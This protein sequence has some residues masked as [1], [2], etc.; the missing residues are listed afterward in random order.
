MSQWRTRTPGGALAIGPSW[1]RTEDGWYLPEHTLAWSVMD[2][3]SE[4]LVQPDGDGA[5]EQW[6]WTQEQARLLAWWYAIDESGR[7]IYRRGVLRRLKGWGKDPFA[8][9]VSLVEF[10]GPC[11]FGGWEPDGSP[12]AVPATP[13]WVQVVGAAREQTKNTMTLI[14]PMLGGRDGAR[15]LGVDLGKEVL[16]GP[17]SARLES[18]TSSPRT[19]EGGRPS[20]VVA[21]ETHQWVSSNEGHELSRVI[22]RNLAK[23]RDG[24]ARVL[25]ITNSHEPGDGS[26]GEA[27]WDAW[28]AIETG[29]ATARDFLYDSLEAGPDTKLTD[30]ASL[31]RGLLGARGDS[32]W[33]D[34]DRLAAEI[35]DPTTPVSIS[36]RFYLNQLVASDDSLFSRQEWDACEAPGRIEEGEAVTMFFDGSH[37]DDHTGLVICRVEDGLLQVAGYWRPEDFGGQIPRV[38]VDTTVEQM[39]HRY[40][41]VGFFADRRYWESYIDSWAI[42]YGKS[43][44]IWAGARS[45][46]K[47]HPI[48]FDM[49]YRT[50]EFC[51]ACARFVVDV[52]DRSLRHDGNAALSQHV[53]NT[54]RAVTRYGFSVRKISPDSPRKIDLT[55]CAIGAREIRRRLLAAGVDVSSGVKHEVFAF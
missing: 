34:V 44:K 33:L 38:D 12:A 22:Q 42:K 14:S 49:R 35:M 36:R 17:R 27:D 23:N 20:L 50:E 29:K 18:V 1:R 25:A 26:V 46:P 8:A 10:L 21:N 39:F 28:E 32:V 51:N 45:G 37:S 19:L 53:N 7:F 47:A 6:E 52:T 24:S 13:A 31:R 16:Y 15:R 43:L 54:R 48:D 41:V 2:W 30:P 55:V 40:Q 11:R 9:A 4:N 5:G 3:A